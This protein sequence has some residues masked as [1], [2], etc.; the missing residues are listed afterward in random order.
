MS[1]TMIITNAIFVLFVYQISTVMGHWSRLRG[2]NLISFV[3]AGR[4]SCNSCHI[5]HRNTLYPMSFSYYTHP[6][7][8][9]VALMT[10]MVFDRKKGEI[11]FGISFFYD[12]SRPVL[13]S[14]SRYFI[15]LQLSTIKSVRAIL[16]P[17][18]LS[19]EAQCRTQSINVVS[20]EEE[21]DKC[22]N[23]AGIPNPPV[24]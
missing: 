20:E 16:P 1:Q 7:V 4:A 10:R 14:F 8:V 5:L 18:Y 23:V 22:A 3:A 9:I 21:E 17:S 19:T 6:I 12:N 13:S 24:Y 15:A 2:E 11:T